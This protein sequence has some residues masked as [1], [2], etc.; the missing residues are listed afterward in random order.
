M[1]KLI[2]FYAA[3]LL[4]IYYFDEKIEKIVV[5]TAVTISTILKKILP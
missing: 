3:I 2:I 1:I 5:K 4:I